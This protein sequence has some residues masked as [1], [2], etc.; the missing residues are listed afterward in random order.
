VAMTASSFGDLLVRAAEMSGQPLSAAFSVLPM[1]VSRTHLG[2]VWFIRI[3]ALTILSILAIGG[4]RHRESR[5]FILSMLCLLG[6]VA[7]TKSASGHGADAG[8]FSLAEM[9]DW[10]HLMAVSFWGG[11]ILV[12]SAA[13]LPEL[14]GTGGPSAAP[15]AG[16]AGRF[17]RLAGVAVGIIA[18]TSLY[19]AWS[20]VGSFGAL[21][22]APYGWTVIAKAILFFLLICLG[23]FNRYVRVPFLRE[24]AGLPR[25]TA[26]PA[27]GG[28]SR[29][30]GQRLGSADDSQFMH[31]FM[32]SIRTEAF[33][34]VLVLLCASLL[35]H[36]IPARHYSHMEHDSG[37]SSVSPHDG[38][39]PHTHIH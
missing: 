3:T 21:F 26:R 24:R 6:L 33:L 31:R 15:L 7:M 10:L 13:I 11:G 32:G 18:I 23:A 38:G 22:K 20:L 1:V 19:N 5:P 28:I 8:D 36:Q 27:M 16:I 34:M 4:G 30:L 39:K 14:A 17:S 35:R 2:H 12:L 9:M 37:A 25:F 29:V